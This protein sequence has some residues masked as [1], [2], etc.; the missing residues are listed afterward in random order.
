MIVYLNPSE[1]ADKYLLKAQKQHEGNVL[2]IMMVIIN[3]AWK[4]V[5]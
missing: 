2:L 4:I 1:M 5:F 3:H